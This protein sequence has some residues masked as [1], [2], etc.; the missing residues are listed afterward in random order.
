[1]SVCAKGQKNGPFPLSRLP[2][3]DG[4]GRLAIFTDPSCFNET[5]AEVSWGRTSEVSGYRTTGEEG[6]IA[7]AATARTPSVLL[8][9][10]TTSVSV[11]YQQLSRRRHFPYADSDRAS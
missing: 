7:G 1:M 6:A 3:P 4:T 10:C 5:R 2:V 8:Q 9:T 11:T